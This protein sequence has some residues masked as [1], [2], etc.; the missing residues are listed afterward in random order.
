MSFLRI[1]HPVRAFGG[2]VVHENRNITSVPGSGIIAVV[3]GTVVEGVTSTRKNIEK[4]RI[5]HQVCHGRVWV[6][7]LG[8]TKLKLKDPMH[9]VYF[10]HIECCDL[11]THLM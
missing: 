10:D 9:I 2:T 11:E 3:H 4:E 5:E 7:C 6:A 1:V 8:K